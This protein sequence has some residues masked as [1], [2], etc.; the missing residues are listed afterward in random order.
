M[1]DNAL[2]QLDPHG[3]V[4]HHHS[5]DA[6]SREVGQMKEEVTALKTQLQTLNSIRQKLT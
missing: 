3:N 1:L 5:N 4:A 6:L 2:T